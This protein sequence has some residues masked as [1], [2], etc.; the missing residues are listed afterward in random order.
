MAVPT[1]S[2]QGLSLTDTTPTAPP[3]RLQSR[4]PFSRPSISDSISSLAD[5]SRNDASMADACRSSTEDEQSAEDLARAYTSLQGMAYAT[6]RTWS[7]FGV[8]AFRQLCNRIS[9]LPAELRIMVF[10]RLGPNHLVLLQAAIPAL[11]ELMAANSAMIYDVYRRCLHLVGL[12]YTADELAMQPAV[13]DPLSSQYVCGEDLRAMDKL[14]CDALIAAKYLRSTLWPAAPSGSHPSLPVLC[15]TVLVLARVTK[16]WRNDPTSR[17]WRAAADLPHSVRRTVHNCLIHIAEAAL[18][19]QKL[20]LPTIIPYRYEQEIEEL[21]EVVLVFAIYFVLDDLETLFRLLE[22]RKFD[23]NMSLGPLTRETMIEQAQV[24]NQRLRF[25]K[26]VYDAGPPRARV[27]K[28]Y[29]S[30]FTIDFSG[31]RGNGFVSVYFNDA[32]QEKPHCVERLFIKLAWALDAGAQFDADV[33]DE[34]VWPALRWTNW[35]L[36]ERIATWH[37]AFWPDDDLGLAQLFDH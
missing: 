1:R 33:Y 25:S 32:G 24:F 10:Q 34:H 36:E 29:D 17:C 23:E 30:G 16:N 8:V 37:W 15:D 3:R 11:R 31:T 14:H 6:G 19:E 7:L 26:L 20:P 21:E 18:R 13:A 4:R 5:L 27:L 35:V 12:L 28:L 9:K 22:T 2:F